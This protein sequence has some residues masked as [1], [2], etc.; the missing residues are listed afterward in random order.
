MACRCH[1]DNAAIRPCWKPFPS[2]GVQTTRKRQPLTR[3]AA[4]SVYRLSENMGSRGPRTVRSS[5]GG[6]M[7][8]FAE[9]IGQSWSIFVMIIVIPRPLVEADSHSIAVRDVQKHTN[10]TAFSM[11]PRKHQHQA[12]KPSIID[13]LPVHTVTPTTFHNH[14]CFTSG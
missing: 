3:K 14:T 5:P 8:C 6:R 1:A 9:R 10:K 11:C 7:W 4:Y 2:P 13:R 12:K